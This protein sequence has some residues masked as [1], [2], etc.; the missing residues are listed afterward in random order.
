MNNDDLHPRSLTEAELVE[1]SG[2]DLNIG[3]GA[4]VGIGVVG[5]IIGG[6][7]GHLSGGGS[8]S[9]IPL[10]D[11]TRDAVHDAKELVSTKE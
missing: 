10:G 2:G 6:I 8:V 7:A 3:T 4:I 9:S 5:G 1:V 11:I